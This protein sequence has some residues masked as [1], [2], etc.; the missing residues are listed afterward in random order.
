MFNGPDSYPEWRNWL[1]SPVIALAV[2][3]FFL[4]T[5]VH[6]WVGIRDVVLDYVHPFALRFSLLAL[7]AVA[8][9]VAGLWV[10]RILF[11]ATI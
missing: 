10:L 6:G 2:S 4:A 8:L 5:L 9:L 3:V 11:L 7:I 1:G